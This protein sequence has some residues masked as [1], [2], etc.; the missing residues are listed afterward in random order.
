MT[1]F[2]A[3][4]ISPEA[5]E[6]IVQS[7]KLAQQVRNKEVNSYHLLL[8]LLKN[9]KALNLLNCSKLQLEEMTKVTVDKITNL[10][11]FSLGERR[12]KLSKSD[13]LIHALNMAS[14]K[15]KRNVCIRHIIYGLLNTDKTKEIMNG[16]EYSHIPKISKINLGKDLQKY[17]INLTQK[18]LEGELNTLVGREKEKSRIIQVLCRKGK[19]NPVVVGE[20]GVGKT[21]LVH[22]VITDIITNKVPKALQGYTV[23]Q[24]D[25][26]KVLAGASYRGEFEGRLND[27]INEAKKIKKLILFIDNISTVNVGGSENS[28]G[29]IALLR[30]ALE[31]GDIHIMSTSLYSDYKNS[32]SRDKSLF[33]IFHKI[34]VRETDIA[35]TIE[36]IDKT[37]GRLEEHYDLKISKEDIEFCVKTSKRY[38]SDGYLPDKAIDL[39]DET[40]SVLHI[41]GESMSKQAIA[42][43]LSSWTAIPDEKILQQKAQ[44]ELISME[45]T[46]HKTVIGQEEPIKVISDAIRQSYAGLSDPNTPIGSFLFLGPSGVGKTECAKSLASFMFDDPNSIIRIDMSEYMEKHSISRLIGSPPG[47]VGYDE[48]GQ[49]TDAVRNKPYSIVLLDEVEKAHPDVFNLLLQVFDEGRLTDSQ[50]QTVDFTNTIILMTSNIGS[51][52]YFENLDPTELDEQRRDLLRSNFRPEFLN[53]INDIIYFHPLEQKHMMEILEIQIKRL[54]SRLEEK[55]IKIMLSEK[56]KTWLCNEGYDPEMGARP[57]KRLITKKIVEPLSKHILAHFPQPGSIIN[58]DIDNENNIVLLSN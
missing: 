43:V 1:T 28:Q 9:R 40:C 29:A 22:G 23:L 55:Q 32:F 13:D 45:K 10:D 4:K 35:Q 46:L 5:Q 25:I 53:R 57:L 24:L 11:K 2:Q 42:R 34:V 37:K 47:Y 56:L 52:L 44:M 15:T 36:L 18:A 54:E 58:I 51:K 38:V 7:Y 21:T 14:K 17:T 27:I 33:R 30:P 20:S 48:G 41:S 19:N 31:N 39:L 50:G 3:D 8:S 12:M 26:S 49:L 16:I 6:I